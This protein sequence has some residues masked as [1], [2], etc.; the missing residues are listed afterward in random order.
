MIRKAQP[1]R[2][3]AFSSGGSID[4]GV[5]TGAVFDGVAVG[6]DDDAELE[7]EDDE[8]DELDDEE[9]ELEELE[10]MPDEE[11]EFGFSSL[12]FSSP[13]SIMNE[14]EA[15]KRL[16]SKR[17]VVRFIPTSRK[18]NQDQAGYKFHAPPYFLRGAWACRGRTCCA[19]R[20]PR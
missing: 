7:D 5:V 16:V 17:K 18:R 19:T 6:L 8:L 9:L 4:E 1:M 10:E 11:L 15:K 13:P 3:L 20:S 12:A 14:Q 2:P